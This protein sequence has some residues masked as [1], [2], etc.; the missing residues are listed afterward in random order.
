MGMKST[1]VGR[2]LL[3]GFL[4]AMWFVN[5]TLPA[6]ILVIAGSLLVG[7]LE[8]SLTRPILNSFL[9]VAVFFITLTAMCFSGARAFDDDGVRVAFRMAGV[10]LWGAS[11]AL[12]CGASLVYLPF[13]FEGVQLAPVVA[14]AVSVASRLGMLVLVGASGGT[15]VAIQ[16]LLRAQRLAEG[17]NAA[18]SARK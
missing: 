18:L 12:A 8:N 3:R 1:E 15:L 5:Y 6:F 2:R 10:R 16:T 17:P 14:A 13:L 4:G 9:L 11:S 7:T